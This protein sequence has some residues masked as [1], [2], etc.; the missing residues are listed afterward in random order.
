MRHHLHPLLGGLVLTATIGLG[1]ASAA[2]GLTGTARFQISGAGAKPAPSHMHFDLPVAYAQVVGALE[3][4]PAIG[5]YRRHVTT[6]AGTRCDVELNVFGRAYRSRPAL[7][8]GVLAIGD[9]RV[10]VRRSGRHGTLTWY[11][12]ATRG[13]AVITVHGDRRVG[14]AVFRAATRYAPAAAPWAVV[15]FSLEAYP[16][17]GGTA[18][19][20][21]RRDCDRIR[22][23]A[24]AE[25]GREARSV[26]LVGGRAHGTPGAQVEP[27][28]A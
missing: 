12:G 23:A 5:R 20:Q 24:D 9:T 16:T 4:N 21:G 25:L 27:A 11:A 26:R 17:L 22:D 6:P 2:P 13:D 15:Q 28:A 3:G 14:V 10:H 18:G 19:A 8:R 1:A 7:R